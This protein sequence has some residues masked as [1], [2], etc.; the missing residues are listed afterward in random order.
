MTRRYFVPDLPPSGGWVGLP[1]AE[2]QHATRVMRLQ[3]GDPVI[4]FDG[5]GSE[6]QAIVTAV[7]RNEC[8]CDARPS[9][10]VDREPA[11]A[12]H[13]GIALPKPDRARELIERLTEL[14]V[15]SVTPLVAQRT[16]RPASNSLLEKLERGVVEACK[17]SGRNELLQIKPTQQASKFFTT[18]AEIRRLIAHPSSEAKSLMAG[19][20]SSEV[21]AAIGPEG[22]WT[23]EEFQT[24][25]D[26]GFEPVALG[27]R[28]YRVE[29]AATVVAAVLVT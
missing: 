24:A 12:V 23:D 28:I 21:I 8:H 15:K 16:Q 18:H 1:N 4:L 26:H 19:N 11:R 2:A 6:S 17:Q 5:K 25:T 22:G 20:Q 10:L 7:S 27:Q 14:G 13:F 29:T 9:A 3:I